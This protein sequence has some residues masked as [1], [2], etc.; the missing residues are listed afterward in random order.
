MSKL[1]MVFCSMVYFWWPFHDLTLTEQHGTTVSSFALQKLKHKKQTNSMI[2]FLFLVC[3]KYCLE[4]VYRFVVVAFAALIFKSPHARDFLCFSFK[5]YVCISINIFTVLEMRPITKF[6]HIN[7]MF[8]LFIL[9][10]FLCLCMFFVCCKAGLFCPK[11]R[12]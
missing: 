3:C 7:F 4:C 8:T 6:S 1:C 12:V 10:Y 9:L 11:K 5:Y 2:S